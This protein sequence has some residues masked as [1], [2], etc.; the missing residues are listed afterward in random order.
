M[1]SIFKATKDLVRKID[2]FLDLVGES[3]SSFEEGLKL[4]LSGSE[5]EFNERLVIIKNSESR[6]DELRQNIEAQLYV[7]T[8][9]PES[10]GDVWIYLNRWMK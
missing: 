7:Q 1:Y 2:A 8:L 6:A 9:I 5:V 3:V 4:Y 10:R